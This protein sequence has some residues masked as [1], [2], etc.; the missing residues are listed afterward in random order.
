MSETPPQ[1]TRSRSQGSRALLLSLLTV[2]SAGVLFL[3]PP[4]AQDPEYHFFADRRAFLGIPNCL[5]VAS[6]LPFAAVGLAGL[7]FLLRRGSPTTDSFVCDRERWFYILLFVGVALTSAGSTYY[8][9]EPS[10]ERLVWDRLPMTIGFMSIFAAVIAERI[11]LRWG[12]ILLAPLI[13]IGAAS[14]LYWRMTEAAGAGDLRLYGLVQFYPLLAIPLIIWLFPPRYTR[15][16][17]LAGALAFYV[18]AKL[19]EVLDKAIFSV[20]GIVSGHSLKHVAAAAGVWWV[21]RW[22]KYR[23][24]VIR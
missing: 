18:L 1:L 13:A 24:A 23:R 14:V 15:T 21:L 16:S 11:S 10:N 22:L 7:L 12:M 17:T 2:A 9:L 3:L 5:D 8:H 6:N 20:G 19:L 4:I